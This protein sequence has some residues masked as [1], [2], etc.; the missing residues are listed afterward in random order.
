MTALYVTEQ[1]IRVLL[2]YIECIRKYHESREEY[3]DCA[4]LRDVL[5]IF[6]AFILGYI[7]LKDISEVLYSFCAERSNIKDLDTKTKTVVLELCAT[8]QMF[9]FGELPSKELKQLQLALITEGE[10]KNSI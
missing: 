2:E 10:I 1:T 4:Y 5:D 3:E 7:S 8:G 6:S 9:F